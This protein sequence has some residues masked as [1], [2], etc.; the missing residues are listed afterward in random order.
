[1]LPEAD[2]DIADAPSFNQLAIRWILTLR[3]LPF[4]YHLLPQN[5]YPLKTYHFTSKTHSHFISSAG[6]STLIMR[7]IIISFVTTLISLPFVLCSS[8][9]SAA[10]TSASPTPS[11]PEAVASVCENATLLSQSLVGKDKDLK[12]TTYTCPS[13]SEDVTGS[14]AAGTV[15]LL[16]SGTKTNHTKRAG[17]RNVSGRECK[18]ASIRG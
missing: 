15:I 18:V 3:S 9:T 12:M 10:S 8:S 11:I 1:M 13:S 5:G 16:D 6:G 4:Y 7:S 14:A 2:A 17:P